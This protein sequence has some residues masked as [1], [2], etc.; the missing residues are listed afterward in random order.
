[1]QG[2]SNDV[3]ILWPERHAPLILSVYLTQSKLDEAGR[4]R[5]IADVARAVAAY[6][7]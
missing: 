2:T 7:G 4:D 5:V 6:T 3:A 1:M